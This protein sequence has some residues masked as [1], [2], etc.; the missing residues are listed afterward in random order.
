MGLA[1]T[2]SIVAFVVATAV[3]GQGTG[4]P[5]PPGSCGRSAFEPR[6]ATRI[7]GGFE[8]KPHSLPW[9]VSLSRMYNIHMCGGTLIRVHPKA[10]ESD[11]FITAA[12]CVED[13]NRTY[14]GLFGAHYS[15]TVQEREKGVE[16]IDVAKYVIHPKYRMKALSDIAVMKL[17]RPVKFSQWI[18][19]ACLP[20]LNETV[21]D[22]ATALLS[23]WGRF[24]ENIS[25]PDLLHSVTLPILN[26]QA[27][28]KA[29]KDKDYPLAIQPVIHLCAGGQGARDTCQGDSGGPLVIKGPN[30]YVLQGVVS[31]GKGCAREGWPGV[32]TRVATFIDFINEQ[33]KAMSTVYASAG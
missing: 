30:G 24:S 23:G 1:A 17:T 8:A 13:A 14:T 31:F 6:Q 12:H 32:Y 28:V 7:V 2:L 29:Y 22:G 5:I 3:S 16:S 21:T 25:G 27:C 18:Q 15:G 10:E 20:A 33:I 26:P 4:T 9:I 19:P 11:I